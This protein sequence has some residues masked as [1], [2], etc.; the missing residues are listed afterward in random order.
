MIDP[1]NEHLVLLSRLGDHLPRLTRDRPIAQST[2]FRWHTKGLRGVR[3]EAIRIGGRLCT[4]REALRRFFDALTR[5][6]ADG[7]T[8]AT[9]PAE[10]AQDDRAAAAGRELDRLGI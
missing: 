10:R 3:L 8:K 6:E 5:A 4:S 9:G 1:L 2:G 7:S